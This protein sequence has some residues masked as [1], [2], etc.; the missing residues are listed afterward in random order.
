M[1]EGGPI[2][3]ALAFVTGIT[4]L[5]NNKEFYGFIFKNV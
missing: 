5:G 1:R 3:L 4:I 2:F